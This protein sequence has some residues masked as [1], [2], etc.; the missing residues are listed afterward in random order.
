MIQ[1]IKKLGNKISS[2]GRKI[3]EAERAGMKTR[4]PAYIDDIKKAK[5]ELDK[6]LVE[7]ASNYMENV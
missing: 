1:R 6:Q 3:E 5:D 7:Y 2:L 4:I